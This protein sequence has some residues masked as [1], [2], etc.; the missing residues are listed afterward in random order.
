[1]D[2]L[3]GLIPHNTNIESRQRFISQP[4]PHHAG[5]FQD[6]Q[7]PEL[8]AVSRFHYASAMRL[9]KAI[10]LVA[11]VLLALIVPVFVSPG[12]GVSLIGERPVL[13]K[14]I[15]NG[16]A[17]L[18]SSLATCVVQLFAGSNSANAIPMAAPFVEASALNVY[19]VVPAVISGSATN[20]LYGFPMSII[21]VIRVWLG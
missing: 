18:S 3:Q 11:C 4:R 7:Y 1:M 13:L 14:W 21:I 16:A 6:H 19:V 20:A 2:D 15:D 12:E 9:P 5:H 17:L 8:T 10:L